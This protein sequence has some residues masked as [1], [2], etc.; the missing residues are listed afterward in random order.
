MEVKCPFPYVL[1]CALGYTNSILRLH[2]Y[3]EILMLVG[4][5]LIGWATSYPGRLCRILA[6]P[7]KK[8]ST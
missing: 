5:M 1:T 2:R 8:L 4:K 3:R 6:C 7:S